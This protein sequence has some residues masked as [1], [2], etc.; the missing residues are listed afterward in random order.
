MKGIYCIE[1]VA[2]GR[3]YYGS[4]GNITRRFRSHQSNLAKGKHHNIQLQ[5]AY[6]KYG[7]REFVYSVVE[8]MSS[9]TRADLLVREQYYLDT[10]IGGYNMAPANGG[11]TITNHPD[12]D[13]IIQ[14]T[15]TSHANAMQ[16]MGPEQRKAVYGKPG[17]SNPNYRNGGVTHKICPLC[18]ITR[19]QANYKTCAKCRDRCGNKNPFF[20]K[21]HSLETK[22][23]IREK[24][25]GENSWIK[26][27]DPSKLSYAICYEITYPDGTI[28]QVTGLKI[29]ADEFNVSIAN[30]HATI[31]RMS[32]GIIPTKSVFKG[33][34]IRKL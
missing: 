6:A 20:N 26:G 30:V 21:T 7:A 8:E 17:A 24:M 22:N 3:K 2:S 15:K 34:L 27:I 12:R 28:K 14:Q 33:H 19:I 11:D 32:K 13:R 31:G 29:I 9:N 16:Q 23:I 10:N 4:S 18:N 5:R 25:A 1:H